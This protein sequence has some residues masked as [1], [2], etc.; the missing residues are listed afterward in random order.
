MNIVVIIQ[1]LVISLFDYVYTLDFVGKMLSIYVKNAHP[2]IHFD[3][4]Q[5]LDASYNV[6]HRLNNEEK[7]SLAMFFEEVSREHDQVRVR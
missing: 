3:Y 1:I 7:I 6:W 5:L 2:Q 4:P